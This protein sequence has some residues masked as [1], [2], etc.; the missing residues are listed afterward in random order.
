MDS[1]SK[2]IPHHEIRTIAQFG[3]ELFD[4]SKIIAAVGITHDDMA[5]ASRPDPAQKRTA[6][7]LAL[8]MH[9]T[10]AE[11]SRD[12]ARCIATAIIGDQHF[13]SNS[14]GRQKTLRLADAITNC[15]R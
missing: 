4:S 7:T 13:A 5:S 11:S 6:I 1:S 15:L 9:D 10:H 12:G 8:N 14:A 3:N 2:A